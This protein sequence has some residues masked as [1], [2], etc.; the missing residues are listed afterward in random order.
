MSME[1]SKSS[2]ESFSTSNAKFFK[3]IFQLFEDR[4]LATC[5]EPTL[6]EY[7][8]NF[9]E[10]HQQ[11]LAA[12]VISGL[13]RGSRNWSTEKLDKLWEWLTPILKT[14]LQNV[15]QESIDDWISCIQYAC[16]SYLNKINK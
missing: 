5:I 16:V 12:E 15:T 1:S 14:V 7:C 10:K 6:K 3:Y 8:H 9:Q 13:I 2:P 11:R 4:F